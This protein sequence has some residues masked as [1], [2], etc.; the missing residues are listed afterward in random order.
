[1]NNLLAK[2]SKAVLSKDL[3]SIIKENGKYGIA[4]LV[5]MYIGNLVYETV[6]NAMDKGYNVD[7]QIGKDK[8]GVKFT[9]P[10][11]A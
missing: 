7:V 11:S 6:N 8:I 2:T 10:Q 5:T 1:M 4:L 9:Q 3:G